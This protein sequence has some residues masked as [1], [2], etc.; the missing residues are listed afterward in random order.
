MSLTMLIVEDDQGLR[1][2]IE[3]SLRRRGHEILAASTVAEARRLLTERD[4]A[5]VILDLR[6][7]DGSGLEVLATVRDLDD[8]T[9]VIVITAF[10]EVKTAIRAMKEGASDFLTKPF[11]LEEMHLTVQRTLEARELRRNIHRLERER[12]S[13][14]E[15]T[16]IL[17]RSPAIQEVFRQ[18]RKVADT[19][20]PVLVVG[21]TGTGKELV[22]ES[23]HRLSLR[24][25]GPLV[26]VNCSAFPETLLE[27]ELFGHEK[28]AFTDAKEA[29]AGLFEMSDGGTLFLDEISEMKLG[30]QAK[31]LRVVEG[32]AFHRI[33]GHREIHADVR[34]V[35]ATNR[36]LKRLIESGEF[37]KD[38]YFRLNVFRIEV[39]PLRARGDD[40]VELAQFFLL[41]SGVS[42]P[43]DKLRLSPEAENVLLD[44]SW[45]GNVRELR[46]V[47]ERAAIL[48]ETEEVGP[49]YLPV[50][51]RAEAFVR[52]EVMATHEGLPPLNDM[53]RRYINYVLRAVD[54]NLSEAARVLGIARNTLK[55][56][57]QRPESGQT[58]EHGQ[59]PT[60]TS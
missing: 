53:A 34:I 55:S 51:I 31:L 8:K 30:Q 47:M 20:T 45:P 29:R 60:I 15:A 38:L 2:S 56:R 17:G 18:V 54:G 12:R 3:R 52:H 44:Y 50:E 43:K 35:A 36:D 25:A 48:C 32:H 49:A 46:N 59:V 28:G 11:D 23:I 6:L 41:R 19:S 7:P 13:L 22:A 4:V 57:L 58:S 37:R 10:P 39:P 40:V 21:E 5:L 16:E 27:S 24:H 14:G 26:K 42:L 1:S 33:G 9:P